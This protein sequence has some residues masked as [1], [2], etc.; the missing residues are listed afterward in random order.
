MNAVPDSFFDIVIV[1]VV[2]VGTVFTSNVFVKSAAVNPEDPGIALTDEKTIRSPSSK[3]CPVP[4]LTVT[5]G[6]PFVVVKQLVIPDF[7]LD[8]SNG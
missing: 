1:K 8:A 6:D 5:V 3:P 2:V 7:C 4:V